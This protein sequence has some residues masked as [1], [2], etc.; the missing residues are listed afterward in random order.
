MIKAVI[1]DLGG[2]LIEYAGEYSSWPDL[3]T[4]GFKAA[5]LFLHEQGVAMPPFADF[6]ATG[7]ALLPARWRRATTGERN[8]TVVDLLAELLEEYGLD[9]PPTAVLSSAAEQYQ[10][11][12]QAQAYPLPAAA[13]TLAQLKDEGYRLGLIS[14]TM[15]SGKAH[16]ADLARFDLAGYFDRVLFSAE[17]NKWKPNPAPFVHMLLA[18]ALDPATAVFVGDDPANDVYGAQQAGLRAIHYQSTHRFQTP[19]GVV[20]DAVITSLTELPPLLRQ[21]RSSLP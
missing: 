19:D 5:H 1:F 10:A 4:P 21:W 2:T 7:F 8:L 6:C 18:L 13:T 11:A 12:V 15:F 3:E 14:N 20:A 17:E 9:A 16:L